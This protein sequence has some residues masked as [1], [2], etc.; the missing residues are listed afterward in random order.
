MTPKYNGEYCDKTCPFYERNKEPNYYKMGEPR[1][2]DYCK[3][4]EIELIR[5]TTRNTCRTEDCLDET[6]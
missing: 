3:R 5:W 1:P 2:D 6:K 4:H